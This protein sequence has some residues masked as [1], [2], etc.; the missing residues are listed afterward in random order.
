MSEGANVYTQGLSAGLESRDRVGSGEEK[1][2]LKNMSTILE[3]VFY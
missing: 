2:K 1:A 3:N